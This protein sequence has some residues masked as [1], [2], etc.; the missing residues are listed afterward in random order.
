MGASIL[1]DVRPLD[2][3]PRDLEDTPWG[4]AVV[5][6]GT[7]GGAIAHR[8]LLASDLG[9]MG[10]Q[11]LRDRGHLHDRHLGV[12]ALGRPVL[13]PY[14][15][16]WAAVLAAGDRGVLARWSA[17][18]AVRT[19]GWTTRPQI[20]VV[21]GPLRL[22]GVDV[23]RTRRLD[24]REIARDRNGLRCTWWPRTVTDM[25]A[26]CS[27][28][29]L[30]GVLD[31]L[32]RGG[33]LDL[34]VLDAAIAAARGRRGLPKLHRALEPFTSIPDA[35][36]RSLLER[37][38]AMVLHPA[39]LGDHEPNGA[40]ELGDGHEI[41]V[42]ILFRDAR[43]AV[44]VDGR[45]SHTRAAQFAEDRRRDRELQKLGFRVLRFAWY[46]VLHRPQVVLR[47]IRACLGR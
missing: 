10:V 32:D 42:D 30:Q 9:R 21:G 4:R 15:K 39:G 28:H 11:R 25:A 6:A 14:G 1:R 41:L 40:V 20:V 19:A 35:D 16:A 2:H 36:Y 46:D 7:Q 31:R 3:S 37:F 13:G 23:F 22:E 45:D 44:E 5:L 27:V 18:A 33:L 43:L 47:D 8:Q 29:E 17:A 38:S 34:D 12:Y 24:E 26:G